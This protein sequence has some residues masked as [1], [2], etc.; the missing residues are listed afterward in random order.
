[1]KQIAA[2]M[3]A[4]R[5]LILM[6]FATLICSVGYG[7]AQKHTVKAGE[8]FYHIAKEYGVSVS[9]LQKA[10]P[11]VGKDY[12]LRAGQELTI[13]EGGVPVVAKPAHVADK[14]ATEP[15]AKKEKPATKTAEPT[16]ATTTTTSDEPM[17]ERGYHIVKAKETIASICHDFGVTAADLNK[18]N[19]L[20]KGIKPGMKLKVVDL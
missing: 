14:K 12:T 10:N 15:V 5:K 16:K 17:P 19:D 7:Q 3:D 9:Q 2:R 20:S 8:T 4:R 6:L 18:W 13:P 11:S 1:M